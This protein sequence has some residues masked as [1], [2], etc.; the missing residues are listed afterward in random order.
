[1]EKHRAY[2]LENMSNLSKLSSVLNMTAAQ[3][4]AVLAHQ[5]VTAFKLQ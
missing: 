2:F 5:N 3:N 4:Q 1:M